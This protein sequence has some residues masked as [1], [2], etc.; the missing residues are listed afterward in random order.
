MLL[1]RIPGRF[2]QN[3]IVADGSKVPTFAKRRGV[4][5]IADLEEFKDDQANDPKFPSWCDEL[6]ELWTPFDSMSVETAHSEA[7][8]ETAVSSLLE[9]IGSPVRSDAPPRSLP[10]NDAN[11]HGIMSQSE[12]AAQV[13]INAGLEYSP[14]CY[15][16]APSDDMSISQSRWLLA[17]S[18]PIFD[19]SSMELGDVINGVDLISDEESDIF[20]WVPNGLRNRFVP[21]EINI[22]RAGDNVSE[23][24]T[25]SHFV[26]DLTGDDSE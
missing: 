14:Q 18:P 17:S 22:A 15:P 8:E 13:I 4:F 12:L 11:N 16:P 20:A 10:S 24:T 5:T 21:S 25:V 23:I 26:V 9:S 1:E 3:W 2:A 7:S 6:M 19:V